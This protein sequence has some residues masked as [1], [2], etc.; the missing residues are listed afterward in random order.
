M[1]T[2]RARV[3]VP[4]EGGRPAEGQFPQHALHLRYCL[5]TEPLEI[6]R[7]VLPQQVD[8]AERFARLLGGC[9]GGGSFFESVPDGGS[10]F[11]STQRG[12]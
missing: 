6:V 12:H 4:A 9:V 11:G 5:T 1:L 3:L 7:R 8:Y 2:L 10:W